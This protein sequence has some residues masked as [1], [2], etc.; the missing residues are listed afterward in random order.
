MKQARLMNI[1]LLGTMRRGSAGEDDDFV[2]RI[3]EELRPCLL[4]SYDTAVPQP[5]SLGLHPNCHDCGL[6]TIKLRR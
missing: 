4:D 1:P 6:H 2:I 3:G 5:G